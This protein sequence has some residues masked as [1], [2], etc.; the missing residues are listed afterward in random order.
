MI[1]YD[2]N[3]GPNIVQVRH[4]KDI[5]QAELS[6][7]SGISTS[8]L[9]AYENSKKYPNVNTLGKI[10]VSLGVSIDRLYFGDANDAFISAVPDIGRRVVNAIYLLWEQRIISL[11]D[12]YAFG[13]PPNNGNKPNSVVLYVHRFG[14]QIQRLISSLDEYSLKKKTYS[15]PDQYLE[16]LLSSVANEINAIEEESPLDTAEI[17]TPAKKDK[18]E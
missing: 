7:L 5:S 17:I 2:D 12:Y 4:E 3:I 14:E 9:S 16:M 6:G 8:T 13:F 11:Y 15:D 1:N 18:T 10:A